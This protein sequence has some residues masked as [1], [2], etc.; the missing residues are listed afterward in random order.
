MA[1][2]A[3]CSRCA[4]PHDVPRVTIVCAHPDDEVIGAGARLP[5]LR[6]VQIVH[7]TDGAPRDMVDAVAHGFTSREAYARARASERER[8]LAL[9]QIPADRVHDVGIV[10]QEAT[11]ALVPLTHHLVELFSS[12]RPELVLTHAYEGGHPDHDATAFA[13]RGAAELIAREGG[14]APIVV[15]FAGYHWRDS[16]MRTGCFV[17]HGRAEPRTVSLGTDERRLKRAM[18][19]CYAT[20][21]RVLAAFATDVEVFRLAPRYDFAAPPHDGR[22][23]Y[24]WF[25][26]RMTG[27]EWRRLARQ[28]ELELG[29]LTTSC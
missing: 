2:E 29:G 17:P 21:Q 12:S 16:A 4:V 9:A 23:F 19:T 24:E 27:P 7:V 1:L 14:D 26:W 8:A 3:L 13:V 15:E 6:D 11:F 5:H 22:L 25:N 20:Q 28:A 18:F 10:D